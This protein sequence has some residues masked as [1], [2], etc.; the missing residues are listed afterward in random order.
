MDPH[1]LPDYCD[2]PDEQ[3]KNPRTKHDF[4][5]IANGDRFAYDFLW[6]FW[7]FAHCYDD[8]ID[9]DKPVDPETAVRTFIRFFTMLTHNPFWD[10]HKYALF[11]L[12][13]NMATRNLDGDEWSKSDDETKRAAA[14]IVRCGDVDLY[15]Y[16][17][18]LTGGWDHMRAVR[19]VR[20]YDS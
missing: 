2:S 14:N 1:M 19:D 16:V 4:A 5:K 10:K 9:R 6:Q 15:L 8:L 3:A 13:I 11:P 20:N 17:A 12:V 18:F 7:T